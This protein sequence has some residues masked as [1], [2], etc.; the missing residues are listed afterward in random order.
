M[1]VPL[2]PMG[3]GLLVRL[4][5]RIPYRRQAPPCHC[6]I[7]VHAEPGRPAAHLAIAS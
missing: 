1:R 7:N 2:E 5:S 4:G 6:W 3:S